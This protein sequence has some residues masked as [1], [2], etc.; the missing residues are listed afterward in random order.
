VNPPDDITWVRHVNGRWLVRDRLRADAAAFLD[1][2][3]AI[4]PERLREACHRARITSDRR[5]R[6]EDPKPWFYS[7]LFSL[8]THA[9]AVRFLRGHD[10]TIAC[11]PKLD[12]CD[13][14]TLPSETLREETSDLLRRVR[15]AITALDAQGP[16]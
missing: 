2:L 6:N 16:S 11:L 7:G 3:A 12:K 9:E 5:A 8:A 15:E 14:N 13:L 4:D 1:H 10:F